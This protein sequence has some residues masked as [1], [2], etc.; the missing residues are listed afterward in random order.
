MKFVRYAD[1]IIVHCYLD[2]EAKRLLKAIRKRLEECHLRLNEEKT[3]LVYC[4][5]YRRK[6]VRGY[7]KQFDFLGFTFKPRTTTYKEDGK[8]VL[9]LGYD[10]AISQK[11]KTRILNGWFKM[12]AQ[13][14]FMGIKRIIFQV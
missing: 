4:Q 2:W 6:R 13:V 5:T 8:Y 10:C 9:F 14:N 3:K 1:D 11:S 7:P 12:K